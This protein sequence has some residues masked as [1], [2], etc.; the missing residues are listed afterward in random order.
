[1]MAY[2]NMVMNGSI[3]LPGFDQKTEVGNGR[4][5]R[6]EFGEGNYG[7]VYSFMSLGWGIWFCSDGVD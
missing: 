5:C 6:F 1:M 2:G 3:F 4:G 7:A